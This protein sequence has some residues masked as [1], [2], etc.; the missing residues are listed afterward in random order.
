MP[1]RKIYHLLHHW[2][3]SHR[4]KG[5]C[6]ELWSQSAGCNNPM[7]SRSCCKRAGWFCRRRGHKKG[8]VGPGAHCRYSVKQ[9]RTGKNTKSLQ[10]SAVG[11]WRARRRIRRIILLRLFQRFRVKPL[12]LRFQY[13]D[14]LLH[15][16]QQIC[17]RIPGQDFSQ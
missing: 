7:P 2:A 10:L 9:R 6:H 13:G 8:P 11:G 17:L 14:I 12:H 4:I 16:V 5:S 3:G 15:L 1:I